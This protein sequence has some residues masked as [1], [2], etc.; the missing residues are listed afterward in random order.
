MT[1]NLELKTKQ[2]T[3]QQNK[4]LHKYFECL[5][6]TLNDAGL[7]M[8]VVLKPSVAI[9]WTK[10]TVKD[11]L[12]RPIQE[13]Y[14]QEHSTT[15][16]TTKDINKMYDFLTRHLGEKFGVFVEFPSSDILNFNETYKA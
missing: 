10:D 5:A 12:W 8:K 6:E 2:R 9:S 3:Q 16:L 7:D 15:K 11:Y 1:E 14:I 4:A 13:A